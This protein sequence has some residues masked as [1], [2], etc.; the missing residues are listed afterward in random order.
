MIE[1]ILETTLQRE[2][3]L[4]SLSSQYCPPQSVFVSQHANVHNGAPTSLSLPMFTATLT[5]REAG[6]H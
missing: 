5:F 2:G 3:Y 6:K 4:T 1:K